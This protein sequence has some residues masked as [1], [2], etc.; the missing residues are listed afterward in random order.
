MLPLNSKNSVPNPNVVWVLRMCSGL[1]A[2]FFRAPNSWGP[3]FE[4]SLIIVLITTAHGIV[5]IN[6]IWTP[7]LVNT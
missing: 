6:L 2:Y 4:S 7:S 5:I 1:D 3:L